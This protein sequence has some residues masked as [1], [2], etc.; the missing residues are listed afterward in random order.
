MR[1]AFEVLGMKQYCLMFIRLEIGPSIIF[2]HVG[3]LDLLENV[4]FPSKYHWKYYK[5]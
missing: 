1:C 2:P 5:E 4:C 3:E